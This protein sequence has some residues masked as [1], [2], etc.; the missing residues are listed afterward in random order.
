MSI[1]DIAKNT[2]IKSAWVKLYNNKTFEAAID[3]TFKNSN[4]PGVCIEYNSETG[5][6]YCLPASLHETD[7][8]DLLYGLLFLMN[9]HHTSKQ[10]TATAEEFIHIFK[11]IGVNVEITKL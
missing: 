7:K 11:E 3:V 9:F 5:E 2:E 8:F 10:L 1:I 4:C 6:F